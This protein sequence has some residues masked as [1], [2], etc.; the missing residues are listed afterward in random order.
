M[1]AEDRSVFFNT[2]DFASA[3]TYDGATTVNGILDVEYAEVFQGDRV[4]VSSSRPVF[5][6]DAADLSSPAMG[7]EL[8]VDSTTYII[9]DVEV[10]RDIGKLILEA[11]GT[12]AP[13]VAPS[14]VF[15]NDF[16]ADF[17]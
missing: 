3:A 7:A 13:P 9:R 1:F 17:D 14:G 11:T 10:D 15:S 5:L 12:V 4:G 8:V 6:Y 16:S 2:D